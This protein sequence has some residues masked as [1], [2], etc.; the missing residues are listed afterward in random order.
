MLTFGS[1]DPRPVR[2]VKIRGGSAGICSQPLTKGLR[3]NDRPRRRQSAGRLLQPDQA[4]GR[5]GRGGRRASRSS[6]STPRA[7]RDTQV[8]QIQDLITQKI[9]ALI[10]IPAGATAAGVPVKAAQGGRHPGRHRRPQPG[11][12]ARRHLHRDRQRRPRPRNS[13]STSASRPA[14][15]AVSAII[16]G[17]IGTTP[18]DR[19]RQGLQGGDGQVPRHHRGRPPGDR[20]WMQDEGFDDRARTC[21]SATPTSPSSSAGPTARARRGA[22]RR[23]RQVR[24]QVSVVGFDGDSSGLKAVQTANVDA[25]MTQQTQAMGTARRRVGAATLIAG[26]K[27]PPSSSRTAIADDARTTSQ[28]KYHRR[29]SALNADCSGTTLRTARRLVGPRHLQEL[30]TRTRR[31]RSSISTSARVRSSR[32]SARTGPASRRCRSIIAGAHRAE[33]RAR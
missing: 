10:Y 9:E 22:G 2:V 5:E 4:V 6:S 27:L 29:T 1:S 25:T 32:C 26:K 19:S 7:T 28:P 24:R 17:Q 33:R 31:C 12:R 30:S 13:A 3:P 8:N 15:R 11:R 14:A 20:A 18:E 16:Q 23:S 21:C